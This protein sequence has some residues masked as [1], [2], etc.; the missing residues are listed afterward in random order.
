MERISATSYCFYSQFHVYTTTLST[1]IFLWWGQY[2]CPNVCQRLAHQALYSYSSS[3]ARKSP[4]LL[5]FTRKKSC[6][7]TV[8]SVKIAYEI[9]EYLVNIKAHIVHN[10]RLCFNKYPILRLKKDPTSLPRRFLDVC[11]LTRWRRRPVGNKLSLTQSINLT[12]QNNCI[13]Y[14][15]N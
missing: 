2:K 11:N 12:Q 1:K 10:A 6:K 4:L 7:H 14:G 13:V 5:D 9:C 8:L 15:Y 3:Y